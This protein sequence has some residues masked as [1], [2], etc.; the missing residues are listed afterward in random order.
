MTYQEA[1]EEKNA[2]R[3]LIDTLITQNE[4]EYMVKDVIVVPPENMYGIF[5]N[6]YQETRDFELA[7]NRFITR[8]DLEVRLFAERIEDGEEVILRIEDND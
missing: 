8:N 1:L 2:H 3:H 5:L 7:I 4:I 6:E